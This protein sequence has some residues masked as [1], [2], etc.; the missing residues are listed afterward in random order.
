M[1]IFAAAVLF[2]AAAPASI[3]AS[4]LAAGTLYYTTLSGHPNVFSVNYNYDGTNFTLGSSTAIANLPQSSDGI[5][6][7]PNGDLLIG[8][9]HESKV[10]Q[11][12]TGGSFVNSAATDGTSPEASFHLALDPTGNYVYSSDTFDSFGSGALEV[13]PIDG[14]GVVQTGTKYTVSGSDPGLTSLQ[15]TP[16]GWFYVYDTGGNGGGNF[17]SVDLTVF[18]AITATRLFTGVGAAHSL[19]W[20]SFTNKVT[21]FGGGAV[22]TWDPTSPSTSPVQRTGITCDFDQ[23]AVDGYGHALIA[24]CNSITFIDY[25]AS[26][27]ITNALNPTFIVGGYN[28]IDDVAP[29]SGVGSQG[30]PEPGTFAMFFGAGLLAVGSM[31]FKRRN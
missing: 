19:A 30:A 15:Y 9:Q 3:F 14:S 7:A 2:V 5:I 29:L 12:T 26:G 6:F 20:D 22:A 24:G 10:F 27:D 17:G 21:M 31:R 13:L 4:S 25:S 23:G 16:Y 1:R 11:Y 28:Q 8:G 18:S